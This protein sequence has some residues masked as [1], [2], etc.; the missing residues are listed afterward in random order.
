MKISKQRL[1][2]HIGRV[3][4]PDILVIIADFF[5]N[6]HQIS[7][8]LVSGIHGERLVVIFR[9]DGYKKNAGKLAEKIFGP[10]G[11][12]GGHREAARAE[13]PLKNL[14]LQGQE[15]STRTLK[16]LATKHMQ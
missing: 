1:Y 8:V 2:V 5:K 10:M 4:N 16:R 13:V 9:C 6:V 3:R 14:P 7:W 12:A 15:F 11:S